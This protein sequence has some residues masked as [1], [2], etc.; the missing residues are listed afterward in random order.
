MVLGVALLN[1]IKNF[2]KKQKTLHLVLLT[3]YRYIFRCIRNCAI[4]YYLVLKIKTLICTQWELNSYLIISAK[5]YCRKKNLQY[6]VVENKQMREICIPQYYGYREEESIKM[7]VSPEI[8]IAELTG[9]QI[10]GGNSFVI[11]DN[12][13][14]YDM[15]TADDENRYDL[16]CESLKIIDNSQA[17]VMSIDSNQLFDEAIF[18]IGF[19]SS[20]YYHFTIEILSRLQYIDSFERYHSIPLLIDE[21]VFEIPQFSELLLTMNKYNHPIIPIKGHHSYKVN[22]LIF[23]SYNT[24]MPINVKD[25]VNLIYKDFIIANSGIEYIRNTVL[26]ETNYCGDKKIFISR[27]NSRNKRLVNEK[28][29]LE[30]FKQYDFEVVYPEKYSFREQVEIFSRAKYIAGSTGAAFTN[31]IYCPQNATFVCIIPRDYNF[32]MYSTL[33]KI[34]R[35]N[36]IFL[37]AQ[38]VKKGVKNSDD[39][40]KLDIKSCKEFLN[41][42]A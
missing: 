2:I 11:A 16:R 19:A 15:A 24:W 20:N 17:S 10:V 14:I 25:N 12:Y 3:I 35:L 5:T 34:V 22:K 18:L 41:A 13:C 29:V 8:Y 27:L 7:A 30:L 42:L 6:A 40:Y 26:C 33:A 9:V 28:E 1:R 21:I 39:E 32:Y 4:A 36:S 31:I 37:D 23:P 38:I